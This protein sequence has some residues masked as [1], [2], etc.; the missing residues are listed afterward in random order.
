[1]LFT[2]PVYAATGLTSEYFN[3]GRSDW[4]KCHFC[5]AEVLAVTQIYDAFF[6]VGLMSVDRLLFIVKPLKYHQIITSCKLVVAMIFTSFLSAAVA[7]VTSGFSASREFF[8]DFMSC[9]ISF[10]TA[11]YPYFIVPIVIGL[12]NLFVIVVCNIWIV[13]IVQRNIKAIYKYR[14]NDGNENYDIKK[15]METTRYKKQLHL[16]QVFGAIL[17]ANIFCWLPL[18]IVA[19]LRLLLRSH[20]V[21]H[22]NKAGPIVSVFLL[23]MVLFHPIIETLLLK[24][25]REPL[26]NLVTRLHKRANFQCNCGSYL[27]ASTTTK[28]DQHTRCDCSYVWTLLNVGMLPQNSESQVHNTK[29]QQ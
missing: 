27:C 25:V 9:W 2:L 20:F 21:K 8:P 16:F 26:K 19:L 5:Y 3:L 15:R 4:V 7:V 22:F 23:S 24:D 28:N 10:E 29:V 13:V 6:L 12:G 1:M 18:T 14:K 11:N 17:L